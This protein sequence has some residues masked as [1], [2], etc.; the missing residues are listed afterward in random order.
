M[1][2]L[3]VADHESK[4]IWDYFEPG[5]LDKYDLILS[6]GDLHPHYMSF[7]ATMCKTEVLYV[8]GNHDD[9][10]EK[11][12]PEGCISIDGTVVNYKGLRI[13][14][15]GGSMRYKD[16]INMYT[17]R[18]MQRRIRR[19]GRAIRKNKGFDI[20]LAHAPALGLN[21]SADLPHKGFSQFLHLL[22]AY[23]PRYFIHGHNHKN[24]SSGYKRLD[25]YHDTIVINAYETYELDY[26]DEWLGPCPKKLRLPKVKEPE[27]LPRC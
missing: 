27:D 19:A 21:D 24:Y 10:Y 4:K 12:P 22:D 6:A 18:E 5:M 14:G 7:L 9:C 17:E 16:G 1:K 26:P 15:L 25:K 11:M 20:L 13:L 8:H 23:H 2:I 3:I